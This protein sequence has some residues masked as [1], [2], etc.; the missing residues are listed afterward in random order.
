MLQDEIVVFL[1]SRSRVDN[2]T[3]RDVL[4]KAGLELN[5]HRVHLR[6]NMRR[7][8]HGV[9]SVATDRYRVSGEIC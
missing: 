6:R 7:S 2:Q 1:E 5:H 4:E 9:E 3:R 8:W